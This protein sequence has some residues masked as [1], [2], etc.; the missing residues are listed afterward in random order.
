[1][2]HNFFPI[3]S[4]ILFILLGG[5]IFFNFILKNDKVDFKSFG[6]LSFDI[7]LVF[8]AAITVTYFL[9]RLMS[10]INHHVKFFLILSN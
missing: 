3:L 6:K 4:T 8:L 7:I 2:I 5:I 10:K 9:F 1:M